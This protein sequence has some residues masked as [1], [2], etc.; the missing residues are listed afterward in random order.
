M[1]KNSFL[2]GSF[3]ATLGIVI[4]KIIGL[5]YVIP[6][7][8]LITNYGAT[9]YSFA[10]SIYA[11]FLSLS[12]SGIPIAMSKLVSEYNSL[13]YYHTKEKIYKLGFKSI[14]L[15]G[16][17]FFIIMFV[18]APIVASFVLG[19]NTDSGIPIS[20]VTLV[21]RIIS[22]AL[23]VVPMLSVTKGYLQGH[24]IM[25]PPSIA[26][27]IEQII[28]VVIII[29]GCYI[30]LKVMHVE[31][32]TAISI[33]VFAATIGA[34]ISYIYLVIKINKNKEIFKKEEQ[35]KEEESKYTVKFLLKQ[36][37]FY[38]LP[39][40]V[41]DLLKSSYNLVDTL[42]IVR[43]L[44]RLGYSADTANLT[45]SVI[46]TWGN[47]LS[48]IIISISMG[49]CASLIP[50]LA[51]YYVKKDNDG[52]SKNINQAIQALLLITIPMTVGI[53]FLAQPIWVVFY[54]YDALSIVIF[55]LFI[56]Q[57]ITFSLFSVLLNI[58]QAT[59]NT[60]ITILTL[61]LSFLGNAILNIPMMELCHRLWHIGYQGA[62]V[63]TLI[64]QIVPSMFLLYYIHKKL[65]VNYK[66]TFK[67]ILIII[68]S[69]T[70]MIVVLEFISIIY[71]INAVSKLEGII[72]TMIYSILGAFIYFVITYKSGLLKNVLGNIIK[73]KK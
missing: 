49:I 19:N 65:D 70:I 30:S 43:T 21:I 73:K 32:R 8:A 34:L 22:T 47:K 37:I 29:V 53:C 1:K 4:C 44:T 10:Y 9:L 28:R 66:E 48:M 46:A 25:T 31:E 60:K 16:I 63:S 26:N 68:L 5:I 24:K 52:I 2:E 61:F 54:E 64:T 40:I 62:S 36:L 57:A 6:F 27:I 72:Q 33:S 45:F 23:L 13:E 18:S 71:P 42:T 15:L 14:M 12:T 39:F 59:N 35:I 20:D 17:V 56:F 67:N 41:I 11:V 50:S 7:Y 51:S 58:T 38:A 55:K 69:T 3:I